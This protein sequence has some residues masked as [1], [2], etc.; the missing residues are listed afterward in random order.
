[1]RTTSVITGVVASALV[2]GATIANVRTDTKVAA[3]AS[4][5]VTVTV[6]ATATVGQAT[7]TATRTGTVTI[8]ARPVPTTAADAM[9]PCTEEDGSDPGQIFP[10]AWD[11][12]SNG[13]GR[14]YVLTAP[15]VEARTA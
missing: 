14:H 6:T 11:G 5:T 3:T 7:A 15:G 4:H 8:T 1:M 9:A 2:L 13:R 12:G 10:C